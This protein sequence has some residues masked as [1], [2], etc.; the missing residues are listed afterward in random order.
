[1]TKRIG[2]YDESATDSS[3]LPWLDPRFGIR[4]AEGSA[5]LLID[6]QKTCDMR[7]Y[8]DIATLCA[9]QIIRYPLLAHLEPDFF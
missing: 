1:V 7:A 6:F 3:G 8:R 2:I 5:A 9:L 4:N